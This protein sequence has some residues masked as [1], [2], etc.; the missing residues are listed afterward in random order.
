MWKVQIG[1][2]HGYKYGLASGQPR[3]TSRVGACLRNPSLLGQ[4]DGRGRVEVLEGR[5][6]GSGRAA[7]FG[8]PSDRGCGYGWATGFGYGSGK[9]YGDP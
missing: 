4:G 3:F 1:L 2:G 6:T 9:G 5:R 8:I 7:G